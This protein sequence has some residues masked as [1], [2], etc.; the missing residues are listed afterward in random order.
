[1]TKYTPISHPESL[2]VQ[3]HSAGTVFYK[4]QKGSWLGF[5][6]AWLFAV[7]WY[8]F[9]YFEASFSG[10]ASILTLLMSLFGLIPLLMGFAFYLQWLQNQY[11]EPAE[12][13][14]SR[15][16]ATRGQPL[17][18]SFKQSLKAPHQIAKTGLLRWRI[19]CA[20]VT[21][22]DTDDDHSLSHHLL[23]QLELPDQTIGIGERA[24]AATT[25]LT[26]PETLP[27]TFAPITTQLP[28]PNRFSRQ[29]QTQW[30]EYQICVQVTG[31]GILSQENLF[32][33]LVQ[34]ADS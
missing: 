26:I 28:P 18:I 21:R 10:I 33:L 20:E 15:Y 24:Y 30:L 4:A 6:L 3:T 14:L 19:T 34:S 13:H 27:A 29:S 12:L 7:G 25:M 16:P 1:M 22:L 23:W 31:T 32:V 8:V 17:Q 2:E 11:L 5:V 9:V